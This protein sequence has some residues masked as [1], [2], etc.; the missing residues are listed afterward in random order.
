MIDDMKGRREGPGAQ[1]PRGASARANGLSSC[2][3]RQTIE[4][5]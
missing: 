4:V 2:V 3:L 1:V 5:I